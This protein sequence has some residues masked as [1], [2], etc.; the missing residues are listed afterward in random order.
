MNTRLTVMDLSHPMHSGMP[1]YPGTEPPR[2]TPVTSVAN[3]G[4][5]EKSI[6]VWSHTGTHMDAPAHLIAGGKTLDQF[7]ASQ[8]VGRGLVIDV[9][10]CGPVIN[11][12]DLQAC[13][14]PLQAAEFVCLYSGWSRHWGAPAYFQNFPVLSRDAIEYLVSFPLKGL[15]VDMISI[16]RVDGL[17]VPNHLLVLGQDLLIIE[18]LTNLEPLLNL[19]FQFQGFPLSIVEADGSPIRAVAITY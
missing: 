12:S 8:F 1:F 2:I 16:D 14:V 11:V 15:G 19:D 13:S 7:P 9:S 6:S 5:A 17:N 4:Y 3:D 10:R 18:N